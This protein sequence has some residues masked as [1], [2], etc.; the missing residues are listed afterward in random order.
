MS[1]M[2]GTSESEDP[3]TPGPESSDKSN[4]DTGRML[5]RLVPLVLSFVALVAAVVCA[6]VF[7]VK[8]WNVYVDEY[9]A[10][11][12]RD[13]ATQ[14][15]EQA[16]LNIT[17]IDPADLDTFK[18]R[19][20]ASLTGKARE[21]VLGG[22]DGGV[23]KMLEEAGPSSAKL[24]ARLLRSAPTE[25]NADEGKAK[26]LVYVLTSLQRPD[27]PNVDETRGFDVGMVKDGDVWKAESITGLE[28][29]AYADTGEAPAPAP[30]G[31]N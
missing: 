12:T 15:A 29:I 9:P 30:E 24:T 26:V 8:A 28:G 23:L 2:T 27:E 13:Q 25:V 31:E 21:E 11:Q 14:A 19:A 6:V 16:V 5:K 3:G 18:E 1:A 22:K 4:A 17:T 10:Q 7:G 20:D